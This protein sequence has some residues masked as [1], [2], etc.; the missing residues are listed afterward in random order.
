MV[1]KG[2]NSIKAS[3]L[4]CALPKTLS[5]KTI[6]TEIWKTERNSIQI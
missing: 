5:T 4:A 3:L 2:G 1:V 6:I